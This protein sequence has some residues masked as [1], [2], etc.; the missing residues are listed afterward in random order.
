[1]QH[2]L[3]VG[4]TVR[5]D[6]PELRARGST[7]PEKQPNA[8]A[9]RALAD[10][11]ALRTRIESSR[12]EYATQ[13][14]DTRILW[15]PDM[16]RM[17]RVVLKNAR[18]HAYFEYGEP[19]LEAPANVRLLPLESMPCSTRMTIRALSMSETLREIISDARSPAPKATLSAALYLRPGAASKRRATSSGLKTTGSLRDSRT[20]G[21]WT[22]TSGLRSVTMKKNRN[23][24]RAWLIVWYAGARRGR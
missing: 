19:M 8:S 20:K 14:G 9:A 23:A 6:I 18:G 13:G 4:R 24:V 17:E 3:L 5:G 22:T 10:S 1:V 15:K 12:T 21:N 16:D 11:A 2:R 7:D